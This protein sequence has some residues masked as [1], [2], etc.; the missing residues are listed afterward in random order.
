MAEQTQRFFRK[1]IRI[2]ADMSPNV[3]LAR[4]QIAAGLQPT[5][6]EICPG[7]LSWREYQKRRA[8][9]DQVRQCV[10]LDAQFWEGASQL[11]FPPDW[12]NAA[13]QLWLSFNGG[14]KGQRCLGIGIDPAEG[15]DRTS[16][17]AVGSQGLIELVSR[18]TP[19][20]ADVPNEA[21]AFIRRH[22]CLPERCVFDA[23]GGGKQAADQCRERGYPVRTVAFGESLLPELKR[24]MRYLD[25]KVEH[26]EE[27]YVFFNRRAEM[28]FM[29]R[30]LLDPGGDGWEDSGIGGKRG[31]ALPQGCVGPQYAE[32]RRQ[33]AP[34][35]LTYDPEGRV[36]MIPKRRKAENSKEQTLEQLLGCSPDEADSLAIACWSMLSKMR[37]QRAGTV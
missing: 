12:L 25:E 22:G 37:V 8:L 19:N 34:I 33:L 27:H 13:E 31:W 18:K 35:P 7:V 32:L 23:G 15:G 3:R 5:G 26:R 2:T 6:E 28:Y 29:M 17:A 10:A 36:K 4:V 9:W 20:T 21:I 1:V 11:M 16:M 24:G 14:G 30:V